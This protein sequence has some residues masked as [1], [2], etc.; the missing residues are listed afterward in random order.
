MRRHLILAPLLF[1]AMPASAQI[2]GG[3]AM[4]GPSGSA[5]RH[6]QSAAETAKIRSDIRAGRDSGQL[7]PR[8]ARQLKREAYQIDTLE[9]RYAA[10]GLS[11]AEEAE[12]F[13]RREALRSDV[14]A[15]RSG[16]R[17]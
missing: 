3:P 9:E 8:E 15:K 11:P 16:Q 10:G 17:R 12:L 1:A 4:Q 7:T 14:I 6:D 13:A 2:W 5:M